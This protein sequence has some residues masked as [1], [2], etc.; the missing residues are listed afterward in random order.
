[1]TETSHSCAL[2]W[3]SRTVVN[4]NRTVSGIL[5][6]SMINWPTFIKVQMSLLPTG[7][8]FMTS[9]SSTARP[10]AAQV[11]TPASL[12]GVNA[13]FIGLST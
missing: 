1:M 12:P 13:C 11:T 7:T 2:K 8:T 10:T 6:V 4:A 5:P 3:L 9:T